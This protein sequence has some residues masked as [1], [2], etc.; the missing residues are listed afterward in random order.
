MLKNPTGMREMLCKQNSAAM[1]LTRV[2]PA[3]LLGVS[4]GFTARCLWWPNQVIVGL[5]TPHRKYLSRNPQGGPRPDVGCS[6]NDDDD[7]DD[8]WPV[9]EW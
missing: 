3:S 1:F 7:D 5:I 9:V 8:D 4:G 2:L 6:T